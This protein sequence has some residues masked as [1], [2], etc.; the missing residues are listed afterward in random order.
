MNK[1]SIED[2]LMMRANEAQSGMTDPIDVYTLLHAV[3]KLSKDLKKSIFSDVEDKIKS[4]G[5]ETPERNGFKV[6]VGSRKSWSYNDPEID[7][8]KKLSKNRQEL[9]K[10]AYAMNKKGAVMTDE[11]GEVIE[12]AEYKETQF[13]ICKS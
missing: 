13:I 7:R 5:D 10:E 11:N 9:A 12:P 8:Y 3:E 1:Q 2:F 4:Y 6:S